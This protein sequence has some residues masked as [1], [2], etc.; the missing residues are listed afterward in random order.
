[1]RECNVVE[2]EAVA[3]VG[4]KE[5]ETERGKNPRRVFA[6]NGEFQLCSLISSLDDC[7]SF[8]LFAR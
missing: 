4:G 6:E 8:A 3:S 1:M 2:R 7:T 5:R